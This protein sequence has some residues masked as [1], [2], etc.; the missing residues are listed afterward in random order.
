ML[1]DTHAFLWWCADSSD[2]SKAARKAIAE[3]PCLLSIASI[4]E[5]AI[6]LSTGKLKL[7]SDF[8]RYVTQQMHVN[9]F[10]EMPIAF[11]HAVRC[12]TLPWVHRDP[13][14]RMLAAQALD[15]QIPIVSRDPVFNG[16]GID[17]I[18]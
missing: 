1:L 15:E 2:L 16:Y 11:R 8:H 6:K 10:T 9:G 13:F 17:R 5:M 4:W 18:W 7:D 14:D 12:A 3:R